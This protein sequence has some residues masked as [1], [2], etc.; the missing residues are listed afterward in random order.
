MKEMEFSMR[1]VVL[2]N[3]YL[4]NPEMNQ[5]L[6]RDFYKQRKSGETR[7]LYDDKNLI[8]V[9]AKLM[10]NRN[11][12]RLSSEQR[13]E[14]ILSDY[15][16]E[17]AKDNIRVYWDDRR[18]LCQALH[19]KVCE[20]ICVP[21]TSVRLIDF[22]ETEFDE[23]LFEYYDPK[24]GELFLNTDLDYSK[25]DP[26]EMLQRVIRGT[27]LHELHY[28]V[29]T[30]YA[31]LESVRPAERYALLSTLLK[32]ATTAMLGQ[33]ECHSMR[34]DFQYGAGYSAEY[35]YA[36]AKTYIFLE[37]LFRRYG[38]ID[39]PK[40]EKFIEEKETFFES[41]A[42]QEDQESDFDPTI[43]YDEDEESVE[44]DADCDD[45]G[46]LGDTMSYDMDL[47]YALQTSE[48]NNNANGIYLDFFLAEMD[49]C[50]PEFYSTYGLD[51]TTSFKEEYEMYQYT[52]EMLDHLD[53]DMDESD[54]EK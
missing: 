25:C 52:S 10:D 31:R 3:L 36:V 6:S 32:Q 17:E 44:A 45:E 48:L 33:E 4:N 37:G 46:I 14:M 49:A 54:L 23:D 34:D 2:M 22:R 41:L 7:S 39:S 53:E 43:T 1:Q 30:K 9:V 42:T 27:F 26:T 11:F 5:Y 16:P 35:V 21:E 8:E 51:M 20:L 47:L 19:N 28:K 13:R 38:L 50:A 24:E 12:K 29:K 40:I 15:Y 18:N